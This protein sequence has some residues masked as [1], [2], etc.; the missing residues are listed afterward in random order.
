M[1]ACDD[2]PAIMIETDYYPRVPPCELIRLVE[3][4]ITAEQV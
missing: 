4:R 1:A 2:V 3:S